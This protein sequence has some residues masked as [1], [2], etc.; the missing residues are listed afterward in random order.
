METKVMTPH[1]KAR[2]R[3]RGRLTSAVGV[4]NRD[5][6]VSYFYNTGGNAPRDAETQWNTGVE[7]NVTDSLHCGS[8]L[9]RL[10]DGTDT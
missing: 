3:A 10:L 9:G 4:K 2:A 8:N 6:S 1:Q 5:G 7:N